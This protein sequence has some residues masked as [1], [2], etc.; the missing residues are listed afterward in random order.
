[1]LLK[2]W[3]ALPARMRNAPVRGYYEHLRQKRAALVLKRLFDVLASIILL[4][5]L[6]P[7][8]LVL[9]VLIKLDSEGPVMFRQTRVTQYGRR[10]RIYKF[11]TMVHHAESLGTQV[12]TRDDARVTRA[13]RMLRKLRLDE[14]PQ[15]FNILVGDMT[16]VGTR[17]EV[18]KYVARYSDEMLATLL[19]P[20]GVTSEASIY[21]KDEEQLLADARDAEATYLGEVLPAKMRYNLEGIRKFCGSYEL[22]VMG[23]TLAAVTKR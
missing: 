3:D 17:P 10:F 1:M 19:L 22:R 18:P 2:A 9:I 6:L 15:L 13:G 23:K 7:L 12:T 8:L 11:R 21:Y 5:I 16:F 20:A 14:L 4:A